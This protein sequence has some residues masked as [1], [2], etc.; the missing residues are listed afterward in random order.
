MMMFTG[1]GI[2]YLV[3]ESFRITKPETPGWKDMS[4]MLD[5]PNI[6]DI[7]RYRVIGIL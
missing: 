4:Q 2:P 6:I 1:T 7:H 3:P 5:R